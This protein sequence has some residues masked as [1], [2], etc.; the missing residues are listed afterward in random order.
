MGKNTGGAVLYTVLQI[1][2]A[3]SAAA[4]ERIER[5]PAEQTVEMLRISALVAREELTF[6]IAEKREM[7]GSHLSPPIPAKL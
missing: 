4:A 7:I 6:I 5:A 1:A 2:E 3:S